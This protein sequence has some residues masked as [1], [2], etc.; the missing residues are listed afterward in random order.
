VNPSIQ[1]ILW[2]ARCSTGFV[3][4][5]AHVERAEG[6]KLA[7]RHQECGAQNKLAPNGMSEDG[8]ELWKVVGEVEAMH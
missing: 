1:L 8:H 3:F 5:G 4:T 2:C 7:V 6:S